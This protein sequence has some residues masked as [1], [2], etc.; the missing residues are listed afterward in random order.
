MGTSCHTEFAAQATNC[1]SPDTGNMETIA[2]FGSAEQKARARARAPASRPPPASRARRRGE[3][4]PSL[5]R[6]FPF[7]ALVFPQARWLKPLLDGSIRSCFAMTEPD[8]ASSDATNIAIDI[9]RDGDEYVVNGRKWWCTGAGSLHCEIMIL[10]G[11]RAPP[12][13]GGVGFDER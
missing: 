6:P 1:T 3:R 12:R 7:S 11:A 5:P 9:A 2:R 8:V 13:C 4:A 10:M